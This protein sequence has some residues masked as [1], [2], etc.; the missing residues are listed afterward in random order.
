MDEPP[1]SLAPFFAAAALRRG[2]TNWEG[3]W[4]DGVGSEATAAKRARDYVLVVTFVIDPAVRD[5]ASLA[6]GSL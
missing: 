6:L 5:G 2:C 1:L 3:G 4:H